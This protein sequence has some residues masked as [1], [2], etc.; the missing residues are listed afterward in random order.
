MADKLLSQADVDAMVGSLTRNKAETPQT[1]RPNP[2]NPVL[3]TKSAAPQHTVP[4]VTNMTATR[5]VNNVTPVAQKT[6][7][8]ARQEPKTD[9]AAGA[10]AAKMGE[11]SK[12]LG[13]ITASLQHIEARMSQLETQVMQ[14]QEPQGTARQVQE[15]SE[16]FKKVL[17]NLKGTP[18]YGIHNS[19]VCEKCNE[20]GAVATVFKCTKCGKETWRGWA[21][22]KK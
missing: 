4:S 2:V 15:L 3:T 20:H 21:P 11:L 16:E 18:G 19:F 22:A 1:A 8:P 6:M 12:Q 14:N 5:S 9:P 13:Q 7:P 10:L 17:V